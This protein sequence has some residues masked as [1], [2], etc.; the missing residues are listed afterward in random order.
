MKTRCGMVAMIAALAVMLLMTVPAAAPAAVTLNSYERQVVKLV[1][2]ER[3]KR[4]LCALRVNASLV[5]SA[6]SHSAEMGTEKYFDHSSLSGE[7]CFKRMIRHGY[8][9]SGYRYWKAGE[10]IYY[11]AGIYSSPCVVV[12]GWMKSQS[13]RAVILTKAFRNI[14][15]GAV[16]TKDGFRACG[17]SVWF[18]T[19]DVGR[20][21]AK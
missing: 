15:V 19:L 11:G 4:G 18:F 13:H 3:A 17:G 9:R 2:K 21:I 7:T 1:N 20:R 10:N 16:E 5:R 12:S 14:G 6:R 8:K